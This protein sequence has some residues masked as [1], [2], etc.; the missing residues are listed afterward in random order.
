M[1]LSATVKDLKPCIF[2]L[3]TFIYSFPS[4][5]RDLYHEIEHSYY[6]WVIHGWFTGK[7]SR[8][9]SEWIYV[10]CSM[11]WSWTLIICFCKR[12]PDHC[13]IQQP[14]PLHCGLTGFTWFLHDSRLPHFT[15]RIK[16]VCGLQVCGGGQMRDQGIRGRLND[17][18]MQTSLIAIWWQLDVNVYWYCGWW[19]KTQVCEGC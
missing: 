18:P 10:H 19:C 11:C 7:P 5:I 14:N 17:D 6:G 1:S 4:S 3:F 9:W 12:L 13:T 2:Y 8:I 15:G 16:C